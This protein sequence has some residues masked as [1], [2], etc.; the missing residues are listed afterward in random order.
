ME[1]SNDVPLI[2][3]VDDD[4]PF[5]RAIERQIMLLGYRVEGFT[6]PQDMLVWGDVSTAECVI[7]DLAMPEMTGLELQQELS[8]RGHDISTVFLS[9]TAD[10]QST[11]QAMQ[12]GAMNVLEKPVEIE[13][14]RNAIDRAIERS[15]EIEA[16]QSRIEATRQKFEC[17]TDRQ[18]AVFAK[19]VEGSQN[20]VI[21]HDM[22]ISI[23]TV[24]AHRQQVMEKLDARSVADLVFI[25][26]DLKLDRR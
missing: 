5:R 10:V 16:R 1:N 18:K 24:K 23:R 2:A 11:V 15:K 13:D 4:V 20:K 21:A 17:L 6:K 19:V 22:G 8:L 3:I 9:G 12:G 14:L 26:T 25:S 7:L